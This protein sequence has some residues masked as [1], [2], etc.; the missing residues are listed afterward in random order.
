MIS[1]IEYS[2]IYQQQFYNL[3][4]EWLNAYNLTE[5]HDLE[6]LKNPQQTIIDTG[7]FIWLA[8]QGDDI[9]GTAALINEGHGVFE[10]AKMSVA[11]SF[12]GKGISNLLMNICIDKAKEI[13]AKKLQLFSNHQLQA[14]LKLYEKFGFTYVDVKDS[15]FTTADIKMERML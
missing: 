5:S 11:P 3:N 8:K 1:I 4:I 7:G 6:I 14:A 2:N 9:V 12:R 13:N 10:V 15:P